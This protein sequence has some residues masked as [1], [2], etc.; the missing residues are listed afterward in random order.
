MFAL[1]IQPNCMSKVFSF[2]KTWRKK[3]Y[4]L[5]DWTFNKEPVKIKSIKNQENLLQIFQHVRLKYDREESC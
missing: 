2:I 1:I 3:I 5:I 4:F